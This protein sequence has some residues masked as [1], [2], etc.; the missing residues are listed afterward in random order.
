MK[1]KQNLIKKADL[2]NVKRNLAANLMNWMSVIGEG[3]SEIL[4]E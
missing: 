2:A 1:E 4:F 3:K